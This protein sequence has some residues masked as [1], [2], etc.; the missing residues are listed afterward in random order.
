M[1]VFHIPMELRLLI[2]RNVIH[3]LAATDTDKGM[4]ESSRI[5]VS[6]LFKGITT[7]I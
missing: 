4:T 6:D 2:V 5:Y 3:F 7:V 1:V